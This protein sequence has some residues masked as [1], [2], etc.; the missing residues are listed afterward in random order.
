MPPGFEVANCYVVLETISAQKLVAMGSLE[1]SSSSVVF[2]NVQ[3]VLV[4]NQILVN[5]W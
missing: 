5:Y 3:L 1:S 4:E 2:I